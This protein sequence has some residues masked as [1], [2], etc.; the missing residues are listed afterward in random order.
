MEKVSFSKGNNWIK[1]SFSEG[2]FVTLRKNIIE[3]TK[4]G[5]A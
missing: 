4:Y 2:N 5:I 3:R 1:V